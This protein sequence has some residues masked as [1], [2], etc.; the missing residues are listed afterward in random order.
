MAVNLSAA[1]VALIVKHI[2]TLFTLLEQPPCFEESGTHDI[3]LWQLLSRAQELLQAVD[4]TKF[5]RGVPRLGLT[6]A[7]A[8]IRPKSTLYDNLVWKE[9]IATIS[10]PGPFPG[11]GTRLARLGT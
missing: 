1:D 6:R 2:V 10:D 11:V 4:K 5:G 7:P 9:P 3:Q 8:E